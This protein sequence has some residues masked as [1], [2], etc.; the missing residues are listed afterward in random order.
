M[1]RR[2]INPWSWQDRFGFV[3]ANEV[4]GAER[5][6]FCA[7]QTSNEDGRLAHPG[8]M[9]AQ[10]DKAMDNLETVLGEAGAGLSDVVRLTYYTTDVDRFVGIYDTVADP[11]G[12]SPLPAR[13]H[14]AGGGTPDFSRDPGRDRSHGGGVVAFG[15]DR[16]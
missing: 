15:R 11:P 2:I 4:T 8:D 3:H 12:E 7:G 5:T 13:H 6:I 14:A 16:A 9:R 1:E 10:F